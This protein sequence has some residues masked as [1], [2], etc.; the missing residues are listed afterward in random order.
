M[1]VCS[2]GLLHGAPGALR[3]V[4]EPHRRGSPEPLTGPV[5]SG[6]ICLASDISPDSVG[7]LILPTLVCDL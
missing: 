5:L 3:N 7:R 6:G 4:T 2:R 1:G